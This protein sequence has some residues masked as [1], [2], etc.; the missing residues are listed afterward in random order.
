MVDPKLPIR[1]LLWL[2]G[3]SFVLHEAEEWNLVSW[4]EIHFEPAPHFTDCEARSLLALFALLGILFTAFSIWLLSLRTAVVVLIPLFVGVVLGNALTH[5]FWFF[6]FEAYV[7][8]LLTSVFLLLPLILYLVYRVLE[9]RLVSPAYVGFLLV[10]ALLQPIAAAA[11]GST[12]SNP[13]L[14]LQRFGGQFAEWVWCA[15]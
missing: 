1:T 14:A 3:L 8:G 2:I 10:F 4:L 5:I 7:P 9:E 11:S 15:C 12:L 6:Y 13:Q